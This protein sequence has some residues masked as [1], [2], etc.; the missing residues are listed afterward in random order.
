[1]TQ[2]VRRG[3]GRPPGSRN[4]ITADI[5]ALAGQYTS[6]A[7]QTLAGIMR[8]ETAPQAAR[9]AACKEL[10]DRSHGKA[11]ETLRHEGLEPAR[12]AVV[13]IT[14]QAE[15]KRLL[16]PVDVEAGLDEEDGEGE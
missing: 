4:K 6:E 3:P 12:L 9:I 7:I 14:N 15:M 10:V 1:M 5:K 2:I 11:R 8:D 16:G 13:Q